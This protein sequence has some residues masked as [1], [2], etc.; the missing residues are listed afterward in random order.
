MEEARQLFAAVEERGGKKRTASEPRGN[1]LKG[2]LPG[3]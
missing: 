1:T 3:S 2:V